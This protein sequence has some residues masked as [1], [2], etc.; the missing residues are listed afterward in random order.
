MCK[1][2]LVLVKH[3]CSIEKI[4]QKSKDFK[5]CD[6]FSY[7]QSMVAQGWNVEVFELITEKEGKVCL[8]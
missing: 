1:Y 6:I 5:L 2:R 4:M 3:G 8:L 7:V